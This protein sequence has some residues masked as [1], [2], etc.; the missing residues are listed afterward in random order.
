MPL[1]RPN[2]EPDPRLAWFSAMHEAILALHRVVTITPL[3]SMEPNSQPLV[4][5]YACLIQMTYLLVTSDSWRRR[6]LTP[7]EAAQLER[8][9]KDDLLPL[10]SKA[11]GEYI[12]RRRAEEFTT[13]ST[14]PSEHT[15]G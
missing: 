3:R 12:D 8:H 14:P 2:S 10:I 5:V 13:T 7:L 9:I 11:S 1:T 6:T 15:R 4:R